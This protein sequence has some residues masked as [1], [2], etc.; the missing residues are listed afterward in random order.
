M[1]TLPLSI[2]ALIGVVLAVWL[3]IA[4][5]AVWSGLSLR[6]RAEYS[7][8]QADRLATL[9]ES[10]P[11]LPL[12]VR[13]DGRIEA[14]SRLADWLGLPKLPNFVTDL[15]GQ[16]CGLT[17]EDAVAL[18]KDVSAVQRTGRSF[19]RGLRPQ[20][21]SRTLLVKG[22][23][24]ASRLGQDGSVIV[25]WFD[26]TESQE[27]IGR[28]GRE[29][30]NMHLGIERLS[31]LIEAAPVPM[32]FRGSDMSVSLVNQA[33]V[34][35]VEADSAEDAV[36]RGLELID[37]GGSV[38]PIAGA[39][40]ARETQKSVSTTVPIT[41]KGERRSFRIVDVPLGDTGIAGYALD[42][43]DA[44][45]ADAVFRRFAGTQRDMLDRLSAG[46]AQFSGDRSLVF[47]NQS[48]QRMFAI[49]PEWVAERPDFDRLLERMREAER[50]PETR[51]FPAWKAE[52]KAW[53]TATE[54]LEENWMITGGQHL[55][56]VAQPV[57]DGGLLL[58]LEDRTE[59]AQLASARDTLLRVRTAT[60]D[61]LFEAVGVFE[62]DGRLHNWNTRFMESWGVEEEFFASHPH[63]DKFADHVSAA[64]ADPA[65]STLIGDLVRRATIDRR[66][67]SGRL[68]LKNGKFFELA[69]V[70]LPD[71]NALLTMLDITD[72][73]KVEGA[74][75]ERAVALEEADKVKTAFV[76][77]MS[78]ELRTPLTSIAGYAE[79]LEGG[80]AGPLEPVAQEYVR[81]ITEAAGRLGT[82]IDRVL[83]LTQDDSGALPL[84]R[85]H[86][87]LALLAHDAAR[88]HKFIAEAK[89]IELE[90]QIDPEVGA[91][92]GDPRRLREVLDHLLDNAIAYTPAGGRVL[93]HADGDAKT[94]RIVVSDNGPGM[95][96][97][98]QAR[99]FDRFSRI[100]G[101]RDGADNLGLG[102]PLAR[103][104]VEAHG[105][106]L[107][108]ISEPGEG[109]MITIVLPR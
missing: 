94:A 74:L 91:V 54:P 40:R 77:N 88:E 80:L 31:A 104:F 84:E 51:D 108:L 72:S 62:G 75:R 35:A 3:G 23:P 90:A 13:N 83:D 52:R 105:G 42:V 81:S 60:F 39:S 20:G 55:R 48:F 21:S 93:I 68:A 46:V 63:V 32:W 71:G 22:A 70:P 106:T 11:A 79:M 28:L 50:L 29:V 16:N 56:L 92:T 7:T 103:Q 53:F 19:S 33:Y 87:E 9:L 2:A 47:A 95:N 14:P 6:K 45:R 76:A 18:G 69:S 49:R 78:Y 44:E 89:R 65:K 15:V 86:I 38:S 73:R 100:D 12:M 25:W 43:E 67:H 98:D 27:E 66:Q 8:N 34:E 36:N 5:W 96:A 101:L 59:Q 37:A 4:V 61:N 85:K 30:A 41:V 107:A 24:A 57:P 10:A 102:L 64:L 97:A 109:T 58:I 99:A 1:L 26:A 82:M 17:E